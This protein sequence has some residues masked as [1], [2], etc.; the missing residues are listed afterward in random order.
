[1]NSIYENGIAD[2]IYLSD[3]MSRVLIFSFNDHY[4]LRYIS[5]FLAHTYIWGM[6][7][8]NLSIDR[9]IGYV[10][11][12]DIRIILFKSLRMGIAF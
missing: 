6:D 12:K 1:M 5:S 7:F 10:N 3:Q 11:T 4:Y 8:I 9:S 2:A